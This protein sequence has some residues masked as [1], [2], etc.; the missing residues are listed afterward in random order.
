ME[1]ILIL[2]SRAR[3][4]PSPKGGLFPLFGSKI[5]EEERYTM[6]LY[7]QTHI[8]LLLFCFLDMG[9]A[10]N[11]TK[12]TKDPRVIFKSGTPTALF[13][14]VSGIWKS[15]EL[16]GKKMIRLSPEPIQ[17]CR[18]E[19]GPSLRT[20]NV[21]VST[22]TLAKNKGRLNPRMGVGLFGEFGFFLRL[23]PAREK[24]EL[25]QYGEV[26]AEC[27]LQWDPSK[28]QFIKLKV[29]AADTHWKVEGK[30]WR[31]GK[32]NRRNPSSL[33]RLFRPT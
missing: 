25:V 23:V 31:E 7:V 18:L 10:Q 22:K 14:T 32:P 20:Y 29:T 8:V 2:C 6:R 5:N 33:I 24:M 3:F 12:E 4:T 26:I 9:N 13:K 19:M 17:Q 15:Y 11:K 16:K 28:W 21:S 1:E 27:P 30:T